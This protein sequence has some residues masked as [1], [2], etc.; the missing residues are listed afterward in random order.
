M[1]LRLDKVEENKMAII[2][3]KSPP[4][5]SILNLKQMDPATCA[6]LKGQMNE[7]GECLVKA[8]ENPEDPDTV[9]LELMRYKKPGGAKLQPQE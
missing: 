4:T 5:E 8:R 3:K 2:G 6:S 9:V 1:F 7:Y